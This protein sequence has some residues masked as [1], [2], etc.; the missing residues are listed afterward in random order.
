M[1]PISKNSVPISVTVL[2]QPIKI[3][4]LPQLGVLVA[5]SV[6]PYSKK[7]AVSIPGQGALIF[8]SH[9]SPLSLTL[10]LSK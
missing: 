8:L 10:P 9:F 4:S 7:V 3:H 5:W 6:V 1:N 2:A